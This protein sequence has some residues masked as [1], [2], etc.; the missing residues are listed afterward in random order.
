MFRTDQENT[1]SWQAGTFTFPLKKNYA[2]QSLTNGAR[3]KNVP[4][5]LDLTGILKSYHKRNGRRKFPEKP[6]EVNHAAWLIKNGK[7][8]FNKHTRKIFSWKGEEVRRR[9]SNRISPYIQ[10]PFI[11][12]FSY[13]D[14]VCC[15]FHLGKTLEDSYQLLFIFTAVWFHNF[16]VLR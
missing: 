3:L 5:P 14:D 11:F 2:C 12:L 16:R 13:F 8:L 10:I 6:H 7:T 4:P 9:P 1:F 15:T